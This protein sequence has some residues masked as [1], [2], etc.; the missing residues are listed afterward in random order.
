MD[1]SFQSVWPTAMAITTIFS[2]AIVLKVS[3][4]WGLHLVRKL[5]RITE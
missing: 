4:D 5:F 3:V 2:G 1:L